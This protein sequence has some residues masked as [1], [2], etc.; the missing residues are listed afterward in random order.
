MTGADAL[1]EQVLSLPI[2]PRLTDDQVDA[3]CTGI[4]ETVCRQFSRKGAE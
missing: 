3:V 4:A 2:Y 1:F